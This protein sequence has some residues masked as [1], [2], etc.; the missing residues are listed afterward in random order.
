MEELHALQLW[1]EIYKVE[2][3][4][5]AKDNK[6]FYSTGWRNGCNPNLCFV[7]T[8]E[9]LVLFQNS[10]VI[11]N[12]FPHS[13]HRPSVVKVGIH[14]PFARSLAKLR[15]NFKKENWM[16]CRKQV[17]IRDLYQPFQNIHALMVL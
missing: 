11:V 13:Q 15:W 5:N 8:N 3:V 4:F 6:T 9:N 7:T 12:D 14:L 2:V 16:H 1:R 17:D 10:R